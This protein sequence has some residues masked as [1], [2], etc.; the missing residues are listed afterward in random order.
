MLIKQNLKFQNS[1]QKT[2][3]DGSSSQMKT[4]CKGPFDHCDADWQ[5]THE[6]VPHAVP[7]CFCVRPFN[8]QEREEIRTCKCDNFLDQCLHQRGM[9]Y[10]CGR[11]TQECSQER[12]KKECANKIANNDKEYQTLCSFEAR[13]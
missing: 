3:L 5:M 8:A 7:Q 9:L 6:V 10:S 11:A 4:R 2:C 13:G 1:E 12:L